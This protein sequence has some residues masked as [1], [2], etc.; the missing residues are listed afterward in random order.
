MQDSRRTNKPT[1][2]R[3]LIKNQNWSRIVQNEEQIA[4]SNKKLWRN[5]TNSTLKRKWNARDKIL[6]IWAQNIK[7]DFWEVLTSER[8]I[9]EKSNKRNWRIQE[10]TIIFD[11]SIRDIRKGKV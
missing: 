11:P 9:T 10:N 4:N 7:I 6:I 2:P 8:L 3:K 1:Q 5:R